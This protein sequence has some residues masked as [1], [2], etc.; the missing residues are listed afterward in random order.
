EAAFEPAALGEHADRRRSALLVEA[1]RVRGVGDAGEITPGW[2]GALDLGDDLDTVG[3]CESGQ[4]VACG[5]LRQGSALDLL[6][7][8][9]LGPLFC[10]LH[11][12]GRQVGE[13]D[14]CSLGWY[15]G[16]ATPYPAFA[17][18][19]PT[20]SPTTTSPAEIGRAHV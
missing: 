6:E 7:R 3:R 2:A 17:M 19:H 13:H 18:I 11:R 12:A 1:G 15:F 16:P 5:G 8:L 14:Q 20:I 9:G 4:R 10:V